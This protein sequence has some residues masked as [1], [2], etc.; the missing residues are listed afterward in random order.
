M[1]APY[2]R[3]RKTWDVWAAWVKIG[4]R[5]SSA[6]WVDYIMLPSGRMIWGALLIYCLFLHGVFT[7]M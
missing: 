6:L 1:R 2:C 7:L 3:W 4:F 5:L